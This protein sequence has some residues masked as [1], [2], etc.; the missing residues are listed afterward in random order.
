MPSPPMLTLM[1]SPGASATIDPSAS[2][3]TIS[4]LRSGSPCAASVLARPGRRVE[5]M[6]EA[7]GAG[8]E[9]G[10]LAVF[11]Q[12]HAAAPQIE[13]GQRL[14]RLP[15]HEKP[16]GPV[17]G[18]RI[19]EADLLGAVCIH[20]IHI[21]A[22]ARWTKPMKAE[23]VFSQRRAILRKRLSLLKKHSI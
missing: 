22:Q 19:G 5:R 2:V 23:R 21:M 15:Q 6:A 11:L 9:R 17:V 7:G 4:S 20:R 16:R 14:A 12:H 3:S 8:A 1:S 13:T 18:D 10:D